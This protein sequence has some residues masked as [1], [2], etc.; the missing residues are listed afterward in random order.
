[1][2]VVGCFEPH[3]YS[4]TLT[5]RQK[6]ALVHASVPNQLL[7]LDG[8]SGCLGWPQPSCAL[9]SSTYLVHF[10]GPL[11]AVAGLPFKKVA[12]REQ[13]QSSYS[14]IPQDRE[15]FSQGG[16]TLHTRC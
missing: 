13:H 10:Q 8:F 15:G 5:A 3:R 4:G 7:R 2:P 9:T 12:R 16:P 11:V 1:V 6:R 14:S